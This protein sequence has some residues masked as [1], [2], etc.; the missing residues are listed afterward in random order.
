MLASLFLGGA[1]A[2]IAIGIRISLYFYTKS[3]MGVHPFTT[4]HT[5][6]F[7]TGQTALERTSILYRNETIS[8]S[9]RYARS[10]LALI[11]CVV[12]VVLLVIASILIGA[13]H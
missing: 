11:A 3:M 4:Q 12:F 9:S 5:G 1:I 2:V 7:S 8:A 10:S 6:T 13:V